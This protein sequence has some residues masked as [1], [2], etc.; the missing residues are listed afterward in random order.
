MPAPSFSQPG[1]SSRVRIASRVATVLGALLLAILSTL[2]TAAPAEAATEAETAYQSSTFRHTNDERTDRG[3]KALDHRACLQKFAVAQARLM[4]SKERMFHQA[5]VPVLN[6]CGLTLAGEN[7]GFG[8]D[9]GR[10]IVNAWMK[11]PGH[12]ANILEPGYRLMGI[13]ASKGDNGLWYVAQ[14]FGR[15]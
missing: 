11:S 10:A 15:K 1:A 2:V 14:V 7:V 4:A 9:S 12:R 8:F 13:G 6:G 5:L 3:R